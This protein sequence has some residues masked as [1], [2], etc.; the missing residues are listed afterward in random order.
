MNER[1]DQVIDI[2]EIVGL[3]G[4][5]DGVLVLRPGPGDGTPEIA[6]GDVF[7]YY[8]PDGTVPSNTQPFATLVTKDYPGD[9]SSRLDRPGA[10][11]VNVFAGRDAFVRV[12]GRDAREPGTAEP[13]PSTTDVLIA[14]PVYGELGWLSVVNPGAGTGAPLRELLLDAYHRARNRFERR[15]AAG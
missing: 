7:F 12:I 13:D 3:L 11:R 10:Y 1:V 9:A 15:A 2:D 6:W 14:H 4:D 8:S 5:R